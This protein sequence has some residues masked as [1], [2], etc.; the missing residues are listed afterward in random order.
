M[1]FINEKH[2]TQYNQTITHLPKHKRDPYHKSFFYL[3]SLLGYN[4]NTVAN[5]YDFDKYQILPENFPGYASS[6]ENAVYRLAINLYTD[7]IGGDALGGFEKYT[8]VEI[9]SCVGDAW[10]NALIEAI[11]IRFE[12]A[13]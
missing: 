11:K 5:L 7:R 12:R 8:P 10:F 13:E 1:Y 3:M 6:G 9:F 2:R 4:E